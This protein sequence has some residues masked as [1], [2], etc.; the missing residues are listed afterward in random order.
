M[1]KSPKN[2][3]ISLWNKVW[4]SIVNIGELIIMHSKEKFLKFRYLIDAYIMC[5]RYMKE[6]KN[7]DLEFFNKELR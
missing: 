4:H 6:L 3:L 5:V 1:D 2:K 7:G